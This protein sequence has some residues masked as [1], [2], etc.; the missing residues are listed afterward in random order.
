MPLP[1]LSVVQ[2]RRWEQASWA[3]GVLESQVIARVGIEVARQALRMS[4]AGERVLL[5][6][7]KGHNG[8]DVRAAERHFNEREVRRLDVFDPA[9]ARDDLA[10]ALA[11]RPALVVD[12]LFGIGLNR[13]L[14]E[15]WVRVIGQINATPRPVLAVDLPSGLNADTG[16][17]FGAVLQAAVTLTVGAPKRGLVAAAA[18][19]SVGRLEVA[20]DVGLLPV[21]ESSA[22]QWSVARDFAD[23][24][25]ARFADTHKG[26]YGHVLIVGG[27]TGF[28]GA[29]VLA[30]RGAQR[31]E[32][33]LISLVVPAEVYAPVAAQLQAVMVH[34][35]RDGAL[36]EASAIVFGPGL[37]AP[38]LAPS[39]RESLIQ[40]WNQSRVPVLADASALDWLPAD[41][42]FDGVVRVITPHPGEAARMLGCSVAEVQA[43]RPRAVRELSRRFGDCWV[44][45]K[46]YQTLIGRSDGPLFWNSSGNPH[47]AQGGS[48]DVLAGFIGGLLAQPELQSDPLPVLRYAVWQHGAAADELQARGQGWTI[49]D[50]VA[51]LGRRGAASCIAR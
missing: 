23:F 24:P 27:S 7:G 10:A 46:G 36:P 29:A 48:G 43:D 45:L 35:W 16:E 9:A 14:S 47:L 33:G 30:A 4:R 34:P 1:I 13:A 8:D 32:P 31:A 28:H 15:D 44:V 3:A 49:E 41:A 39:L 38:D 20:A 18:M 25:P 11:A 22:W 50:L 42:T 40:I 37:A 2:M 6:A 21:A 5:L 51:Q 17:H 12:G 19:R 26:T